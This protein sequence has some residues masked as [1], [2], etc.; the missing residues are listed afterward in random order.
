MEWKP[1][2]GIW[3]PKFSDH[4]KMYCINLFTFFK[5]VKKLN[6]TLS[7]NMALM[8]TYKNIY[9]SMKYSKEQEEYLY[10]VLYN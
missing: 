8:L 6:N 1:S 4:D 7:E 10:K 9:P 2:T 3:N 5:D